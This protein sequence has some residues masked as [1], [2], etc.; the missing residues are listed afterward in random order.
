MDKLLLDVGDV[1]RWTKNSHEHPEDSEYNYFLVME[2]DNSMR[3]VQ[4]MY[5]KN[6]K[7]IVY[8]ADTFSKN[9]KYLEK[10]A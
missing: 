1:W 9:M 7:T 2:V 8:T 10:I 6:S 4:V 5:L 3:S